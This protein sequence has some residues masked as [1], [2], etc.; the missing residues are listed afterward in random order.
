MLVEQC[1]YGNRW[2]RVNP[3]AKGL[4]A[5]CGM[6]AAFAGLT[7]ANA[8]GVALAI[9]LV[10]V[11]GAGIRPW[12]YLRVAAP[13]LSFL[14]LSAATLPLSIGWTGS[15]AWL[16]IHLEPE[17]V[18][19][20]VQVCGRSLGALTALLFFALTTPMTDSIALLRRLKAPEVLL[21]IMT[22]CYRVLFVFSEAVHD[23]VAAQTARLGYATPR[24]TIRSLGNLTA[25]LT[26]QIWQRSIALHHGALARNGDGPLLFL[27]PEY[28]NTATALCM[29]AL[30]G[31]GLILLALVAP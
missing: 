1:A 25:N 14:A 10:T 16:S 24:L 30:G 6:V 12:R 15:P 2:R 7:P 11:L 22:L 23:T 27:E 19:R 8:F 20:A 3:A 9:V 18:S 5:F 31:G 29:A 17:G 4:F 21:D 13:A 28:P 26:L